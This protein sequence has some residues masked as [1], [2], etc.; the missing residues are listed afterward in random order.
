MKKTFLGFIMIGI[1]VAVIIAAQ[2]YSH[3]S[4]AKMTDLAQKID[5]SL[6]DDDYP[7][8]IRLLNELTEYYESKDD[9]MAT[10]ISHDR[11]DWISVSLNQL[12]RY[13]EYEEKADCAAFISEIK[14]RLEIIEDNEKIKLN[15][16]L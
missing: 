11:I 2:M 6:Q 5:V 9:L 8:C 16:I 12:R 1:A 15:N 3:N 14:K 13:L 7:R 10:F 4:I